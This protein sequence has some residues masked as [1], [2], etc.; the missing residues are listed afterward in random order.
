MGDFEKDLRQKIEKDTHGSSNLDNRS[1]RLFGG[2]ILVAIGGALLA[3]QIGADVPY[4]LFSW[5]V[6]LIA[7]G[8]FI[9]SRHSFRGIGWLFPILIGSVFLLEDFV[10][11][12]TIQQYI[13]PVVII[14]FGLFM[15]ARPRHRRPKDWNWE[16][17]ISSDDFIDA[18]SV[19]GGTR[20]NI[21]AKDFKGGDI[22]TFF[23]G[24]DLNL[25]QADI[26]GKV[27]I[28]IT[29][30]FGGTKLIIPP[31]WTLQS[32]VVC[33]FG[34]IEDKRPLSK[35]TPDP[36]KVLVLRGTCVFGGIDI[37]SF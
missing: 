14:A 26:Q 7:I 3:R 33:V 16:T 15:M 35:E 25:T 1:G 31:N 17:Q 22:T 2:L 27:V 13:W 34:G 21:I 5:K 18:T 23:G 4:W 6:L 12:L 36:T 11:G 28:D 19:F 37:R 29:Q 20:K 24:T 32:E 8:L 10:P 30:V 9:G